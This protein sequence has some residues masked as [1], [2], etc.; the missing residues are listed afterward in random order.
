MPDP[1]SWTIKFPKDGAVLQ[2]L[3]DR[4]YETVNVHRLSFNKWLAAC[5]MDSPQMKEEVPK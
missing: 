1:R 3:K 4:Y 2:R 5:I